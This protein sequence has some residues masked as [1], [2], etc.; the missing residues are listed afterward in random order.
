MTRCDEYWV[1]HILAIKMLSN[2]V[3]TIRLT[4]MFG[5]NSCPITNYL[6]VKYF[7][8]E[9]SRQKVLFSSLLFGSALLNIAIIL[10]SSFYLFLVTICGLWQEHQFCLS[11]HHPSKCQC[12]PFQ[13]TYN[14]FC[15][16]VKETHQ[17]KKMHTSDTIYISTKY[18]T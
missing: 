6:L 3:I 1:K 12:A 14:V 7:K 8:H 5:L 13:Y 18:L 16:G 10:T 17:K 4:E 9:I 11:H 2:V 15:A